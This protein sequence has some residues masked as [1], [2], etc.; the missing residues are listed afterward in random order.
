MLTDSGNL[1]MEKTLATTEGVSRS[2]P[3]KSLFVKVSYGAKSV[4][5]KSLL[6]ELYL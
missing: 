5:I 4:A 2:L 1:S 6:M 3:S